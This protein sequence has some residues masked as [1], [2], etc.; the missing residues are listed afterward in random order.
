MNGGSRHDAPDFSVAVPVVR[1]AL[2]L[3]ATFFPVPCDDGKIK[4]RAEDALFFLSGHMEKWSRWDGLPVPDKELVASLLRWRPVEIANRTVFG[5][6]LAILL[7]DYIHDFRPLGD[8]TILAE[9]GRPARDVAQECAQEL[10]LERQ[11]RARHALPVAN[12]GAFVTWIRP[13][14]SGADAVQARYS[15]DVEPKTEPEAPFDLGPPAQA[16]EVAVPVTSLA[17]IAARLDT[18]FGHQH[19][20]DAVRTIFSR[21]RTAGGTQPGGTWV[22]RAGDTRMLSAP[23]GTGKNVVAELL[24]CWASNH[25]MVTTLLVPSNAVVVRTA[26]A[27]E[28]SMRALGIAGEAVPLMSANSVQQ[29]AEI[30]AT[31]GGGSGVGAWA[32]GRLAYGCGMLA[33]AQTDDAVDTWQLGAEPCMKLQRLKDDG[34]VSSRCMMCP[35]KPT[36]GK[37]RQARQACRARVIVTS[38]ANFYA[39]RLRVPVLINGRVEESPSVEEV[40]LYR[41]HLILIDETDAFQA[42]MISH[43]AR[44]LDLATRRPRQVSPL[45]RFDTE[46]NGALGRMGVRV[47]G[48]VHAA[49]TQARYLAENYNRHLAADHFRRGRSKGHPMFGRW[50]LPRRWDAWLAA[51]LFNMPEDQ[52]PSPALVSVLQGMFPME[53]R[54]VPLPE[55]LEPVA[56]AL[57]TLVTPSAGDLFD[58]V[59]ETIFTLLAKNPHEGECKL[60]DDNVRAAVT[61]R[62]IRRA[63]LEPLRKLLFTLV[64][65]APELHASGVASATEIA[66]ALSQFGAW[67]AAPHGP[68]GRVLFAFTEIHDAERP[69]DTALRV[70]GFGGDPHT[71]VTGL[72]DLTALAHAGQQRIVVGLSA[73]GY[74][75][76]APHHHVH[77]R[78]SWWVPDD[79][80]GGVVIRAAPIS[81][82]E[83]QFLRVSGTSGVERSDNLTNLG[84]LLWRKRLTAAVRALEADPAT[85]HKARLLLAVTS[86]DGGLDLA[87]GISAAGVPAPKILVAVRPRLGAGIVRGTRWTELPADRLEEFGRTVGAAPGSVLIAPL[88]RA[89]RGLNIVDDGGRPL[90][91]SV[92][93]VVR[94]IPVIDEPA[95][96][97]AHVNSRA[98]AEAT[99]TEDPA[100]VLDLMWI[101]AGKHYD[102]LFNSLPYF[103]SLPEETQLAIACEILNGL[104]QL[105]G[106][107]RRGGEATDIWLVDYAF[108]DTSGKSDL[109]ALIRRIRARWDL[110]GHLPL[111]NSLYGET[112][113]A[114]FRFADERTSDE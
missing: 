19:R 18:A 57:Q 43:G 69:R 107:A 59:W 111:M 108:H 3:A 97:L 52:R 50:L 29:E 102:E 1:G 47:E 68:L 12:T 39:G 27:I 2:A 94:P 38:H 114:I 84:R 86:Y 98:H 56:D 82:E 73:T 55:W 83:K 95:Q 79:A 112:L 81:D 74:F 36:C 76:G 104:I 5:E 10:W 8:G 11:A 110:D 48:R 17:G 77:V 49:L 67:R 93:L 32:Y 13:G 105:A 24:A 53:I 4:V 31:M 44:H 88:A 45:R 21:L 30:A 26:A 7:P 87:A 106:R 78:P 23:T 46:F 15:L 80:A 35:F 34:T 66:D 37:F 40:L 109:P 64:H 70:S 96:L 51:V 41:S 22:L 60:D 14:P 103:R 42:S 58:R 91:G 75:P 101:T 71:Y 113:N 72:G 61:D 63:Y 90:I 28:E 33:A 20:A 65:A 100:A 89:E 62:L 16:S 6:L 85:A 25:D 92:W 54:E 9:T 99:P